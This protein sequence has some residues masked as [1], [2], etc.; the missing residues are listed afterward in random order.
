MQ[1]SYL[2]MYSPYPV[3]IRRSFMSLCHNR[4]DF[5]LDMGNDFL[6]GWL[7]QQWKASAREAWVLHHQWARAGLLN[8]TG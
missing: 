5:I 1:E 6:A 2:Q 7:G 8:S 3:D 4:E